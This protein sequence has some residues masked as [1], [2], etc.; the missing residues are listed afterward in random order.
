MSAVNLPPSGKSGPPSGIHRPNPRKRPLTRR[1]LSCLPCRQHKLR[2]DRHVPCHTCTRYRREDECRQHPAPSS[3]LKT[4]SIS[5]RLTLPARAIAPG[6]LHIPQQPLPQFQIQPQPQQF[7][8]QLTPPSPVYIKQDP[9][10]GSSAQPQ[11]QPQRSQIVRE[12]QQHAL[13]P[14]L[15]PA[16]L[17]S[18]PP[19]S[20]SPSTTVP[21]LTSFYAR[22]PCPILVPDVAANVR[23]D[24]ASRSDLSLLYQ[25]TQNRLDSKLFWKSQL[26]T[27]LPSESQCD[28]LVGYYIE[29]IDWLY[30]SIHIPL[31]RRQYS[32]FWAGAVEQVDLI[33]LA[34]LYTML[35]TVA[36]MIPPDVAE[37][38]G[39]EHPSLA[40]NLAR[41]WHL[42][43]RQAL[44][45]GEFDSKPCITQMQVF[46]A[47]QLYWLE[48]KNVEALN[49]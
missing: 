48:T 44:H 47:T 28:R 43:S 30:H 29:N 20:S 49:S 35:S 17:P 18:P 3:L 21:P 2:C 23:A 16:P 45:A 7:Q 22:S 36:I 40:T 39:F 24:A 11:P 38:M 42:A 5:P 10:D 15:P 12:Q 6:P 34:L 9:N 32:S 1:T 41:S 19:T 8:P 13:P 46:L 25:L 27:L 33:W 37:T 14:T 31:F 4:T 26:V